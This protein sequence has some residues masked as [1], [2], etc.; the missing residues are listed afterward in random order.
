MVKDESVHPVVLVL[1]IAFASLS[2]KVCL[3]SDGLG[4][5]HLFRFFRQELVQHE[6]AYDGTDNRTAQDAQLC[7]VQQV[8][9]LGTGIAEGCHEHADCEADAA[10]HADAGK[11]FPVGILGHLDDAELDACPREA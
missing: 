6:T 9:M 2:E 7:I 5:Q 3:E 4:L 10:E 11:G 8:C 1:P